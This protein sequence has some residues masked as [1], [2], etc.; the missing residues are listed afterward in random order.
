[1]RMLGKKGEIYNK[2][3]CKIKKRLLSMA[4]I[5][6][7]DL[8][9]IFFPGNK[10]ETYYGGFGLYC[11]LGGFGGFGGFGGLYGG[12]DPLSTA[13]GIIYI[14]SYEGIELRYYKSEPS[15][16]VQSSESEIL[17]HKSS[18]ILNS[19]W[20]GT[21]NTFPAFMPSFETAPITYPL[22]PLV[23]EQPW[24]DLQAEL[25][26]TFVFPKTEAF[27]PNP[28]LPDVYSTFPYLTPPSYLQLLW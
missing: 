13:G 4:L 17:P 21:L 12:L 26:S 27:P 28:Y 1:M 18:F 23:S 2:G 14:P 10:T 25:L 3:K 11:G 24:F 22:Y 9:L 5:L 6:T 15:I 7:L 20:L 19:Q 16:P 8:T